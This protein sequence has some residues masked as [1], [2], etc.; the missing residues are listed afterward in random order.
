MEKVG[1]RGYMILE[2]HPN[3]PI[4]KI[5]GTYISSGNTNFWKKNTN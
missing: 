3:N 1:L 4:K 5:K 2:F